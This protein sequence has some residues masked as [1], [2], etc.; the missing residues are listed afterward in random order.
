LKRLVLVRHGRTAWNDSGRF[1]GQLDI[2]LDEEGQRQADLVARRLATETVDA[3][4][5]SDLVRA[6]ATA[7]KIGVALGRVPIADPALREIHLGEWQG[8]CRDELPED[9]HERFRRREFDVPGGE[10]VDQVRARLIGFLDR[11]HVDHPGGSVL[12]VG[13]GFTSR[14]LCAHLFGVPAGEIPAMAPF[15]NTAVTVV[16]FATGSPQLLLGNDVSHLV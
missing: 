2:P 1:Q 8:L 6:A 3:L 13:H 7:E 12:A 11:L 10:T 15:K 5:T 4:Y 16:S 9:L 14:M